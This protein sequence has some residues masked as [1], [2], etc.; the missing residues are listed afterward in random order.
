M[1]CSLDEAVAAL[2]RGEPVAIPTE[3]VYGLAAPAF[4]ERAVRRVFE[5]K[6]RPSTNPLIVHVSS[7]EMAKSVVREWPPEADLLAKRFWPGPLTMVLAKAASAP[8]IV[9]AGGDTVAVR[10]PDHPLA[11][12]LIE[13]AGPVVAPSANRS[14]MIS[15][16]SAG[17]VALAMEEESLLV[18]DG[19]PCRAGIESTVVRTAPKPVR[20]LRLG[21]VT[22]EMLGSA[23]GEDVVFD[24][25]GHSAAPPALSASEAVQSPGLIGKHYAPKTPARLFARADWER[26]R[27]RVGSESVAVLWVGSAGGRLRAGDREWLLAGD[28]EGY[29]SGLYA[30]MRAADSVGVAV[31]LIEQPM[32]AG[33]VWDAVR[34]RLGRAVSTSH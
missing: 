12:A 26:E 27:S 4:D 5:L 25:S 14:G 30:A 11:L 9:T 17:D 33:G 10:V 18:L 24:A 34:D 20:V 15:P 22:V 28:A 2:K 6:R 23:L 31:I 19:G 29:A 32:G 3:T 16:T 1:L 21:V 13:R 7:V 8:S